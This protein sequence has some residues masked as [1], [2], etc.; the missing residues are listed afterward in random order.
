MVR[1]RGA[2]G[3]DNAADRWAAELEGA[4]A[5]VVLPK[6]FD[7]VGEELGHVNTESPSRLGE[8]AD[9]EV[10]P[11][12]GQ[13][14]HPAVA[15]EE[16]LVEVE[17]GLA[18]GGVHRCIRA[19]GDRGVAGVVGRQA[20]ALA[21]DRVHTVGSCDQLCAVADGLRSPPSLDL[22]PVGPGSD[23]CHRRLL[24][25]RRARVRRCREQLVVELVAGDDVAV[26]RQPAVESVERDLAAVT[27]LPV[28]ERG[29][30][31]DGKRCPRLEALEAAHAL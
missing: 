24:V 3:L 23:R 21:N 12:P 6:A 14:E 18:D 2:V 13:R 11:S 15:G 17:G 30:V 1:S 16:V 4:A 27:A 26:R 31:R 5:G 19:L 7:E 9:A 25:D 10:D 8:D 20:L 22:D 28:D 29:R